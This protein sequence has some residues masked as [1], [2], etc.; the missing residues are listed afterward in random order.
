MKHK[1]VNKS[2]RRNQGTRGAVTIFLVIILVPCIVISSIFVDLSR[3]QMSKA[4]TQSAADLALN[5]LLTNYDG[6]LKEWYGLIGSC[7]NIKQFYEVSAQYFLRT[8]SS[9]GLSDDE[10]LLLS[11]VYAD[12][13]S[14]DTI[15]DL[16]QVESQTEGGASITEVSGADLSNPTL[17]KD[18]IVEF[19]KYRAP[20][21]ITTSLIERLKKPGSGVTSFLEADEN[22]PL[23]KA[24]QEYCEAEGNLMTAAVNSYFA[25]KDYQQK[26][27]DLGMNNQKLKDYQ[28]K[29]NSYREPYK[30]IHRLAVSYLLNTD[31]LRYYYRL[32][33]NNIERYQDYEMTDYSSYFSSQETD[34]ESG[35]TIYHIN[36]TKF[37]QHIA[38]IRSAISSFETAKENYEEATAELMQNPPTTANDINAVQWWVDMHDAVA[39][40]GYN[41][42]DTAVSNAAFRMMDWYTCMLALL[43]CEPEAVPN[44]VPQGYVYLPADWRQQLETECSRI[45]NYYYNCLDSSPN[46]SDPYVRAASKFQTISSQY[47]SYIDPANHR[48]TVD[49][50]SMKLGDALNYI[51][52]QYI[53][54]ER[55][56]DQVISLLDIAINGDDNGTPSL[57]ELKGLAA[58]YR[59]KMDVY[60]NKAYSSTTTMAGEERQFIERELQLQEKIN[61]DSVEELKTRLENIRGQFQAL[62]DAINSLKYG[63]T[64]LKDIK[65]FSTFETKAETKVSGGSIPQKQP[66]IN[67]YA[68]NTFSQLF[69]PSSNAANLSN[70]NSQ[71]HDPDLNVNKPDL[72]TYMCDEF[73]DVTRE[74]ME[75]AQSDEDS[76]KGKQEE[77]E[78]AQKER[79]KGYRG[80]GS[81]IPSVYDATTEFS[82]SDILGGI[83][84]IVESLYEGNFAGIRDDMYVTT[85]IM[86]MFSYATFDRQAMYNRLS[87]EQ[88]LDMT[89]SDPDT[90]FKNCGVYG[91]PSGDLEAQPGTFVST[92]VTDPYNKSLTNKM[93]S[94]TNNQAYLAEVE[95]ILYGRESPQKDLDAAFGQI[96]TLRFTL[97]TISAFQYYWSDPTITMVAGGISG[98][99]AGV[100]PVPVIKAVMLPILAAIETCK[101]NSR[102]AA[103]MPVELYKTKD[104]WWVIPT[105]GSRSF[106][107]F[108]DALMSGA[109]LESGKNKDQ[110]LFYSDYLMIFVYSGLSGGGDLESDMYKRIAEAIEANMKKQPGIDGGYSL[111]NTK[112]YFTLNATLRVKPLMVALPY[113]FDDYSDSM[114]TTTDW[115]TYKVSITRGYS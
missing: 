4:Q 47:M 111:S 109:N 99:T 29:I 28:D 33:L 24:K 45:L 72:Y 35:V 85:Y 10:I 67:T 108:V 94:K 110:G 74:N 100:V 112:M 16:L 30:E 104:D 91:N 25:I 80:G 55:E 97:N 26:A 54:M 42:K 11:G 38:N 63:G 65:N 12:A 106:T 89:T 2:R 83:V 73:A 14:D 52:N 101:D 21:E 36:G 92:L 40:N 98:L 51:A 69:A 96:Y 13:T 114:L 78:N 62:K 93:I 113:Y 9:Q 6:D 103:G 88:K 50:Q 90:Y 56:L 84:G 3:V 22:E 20:I 41:N 23:V 105:S 86:E 68:S 43:E 95:H 19:M 76:A 48:V 49:G 44:P 82:L 34:A 70:L 75:D 5:T 87:Q 71:D 39:G 17:L 61:D 64:C 8:I 37:N 7:Q 59:S 81:A 60:K 32:V 79:A 15:F 1:K 53:N 102:L 46:T 27:S 66:D 18:Q 107:A 58:T 31:D 115:C 77:Y 57:S